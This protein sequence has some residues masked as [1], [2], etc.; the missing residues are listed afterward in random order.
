MKN[1][2]TQYIIL[3]GKITS[4]NVDPKV[5]SLLDEAYFLWKNVWDST[6]KG[7]GVEKK[8]LLMTFFDNILFL[9]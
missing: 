1:S 3:P 5:V 8:L 2:K 9:L 4:P 6:F 7:N